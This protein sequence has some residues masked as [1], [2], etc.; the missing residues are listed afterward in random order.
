M[1]GT[2]EDEQ[3]G[4]KAPGGPLAAVPAGHGRFPEETVARQ[5]EIDAAEQGQGGAAHRRLPVPPAAQAL[6][7]ALVEPESEGQEQ[8][9]QGQSGQDQSGRIGHQ[10]GGGSEYGHGAAT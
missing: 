1:D 10:S 8:V 3:G 9:D 4:G 5:A 2:E 6:A 7:R